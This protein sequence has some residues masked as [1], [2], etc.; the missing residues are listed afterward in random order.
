[1]DSVISWL[2]DGDASIRYMTNRDLLRSDADTLARLQTHIL[3][4]GFCARLLSLKTENGHWGRHYYQ[5]KWTSTHYTLLEL[6]DLCLPQ[7]NTVCS[8]AVWRMFD[9]CQLESGA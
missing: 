5:P 1:M 2:L 9:E 4:E 6:K 3:F 8:K 7:S